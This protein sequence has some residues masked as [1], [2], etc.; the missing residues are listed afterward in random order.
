MT[1]DQILIIYNINRD[2]TIEFLSEKNIFELIEIKEI[3][4]TYYHINI[5]EE[6]N[7]YHL[8]VHEYE[9][10]LADVIKLK[11]QNNILT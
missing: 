4:N 2:K 11:Q 10:V 8:Y 3:L 9:T 6:Y 1:S 5:I 7:P